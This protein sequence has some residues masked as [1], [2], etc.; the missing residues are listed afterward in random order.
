MD[1]LRLTRRRF[2]GWAASAVAF[3]T[4][5][6]ATSRPSRATGDTEV[7][8]G[9]FV[10]GDGGRDAT[11]LTADGRA[12]SVSITPDAYVTHGTDGIVETLGTFVPGEEV[13][14][15]G[16][17]STDGVAAVEFQSVYANATGRLVP[18]NS[19]YVLITST[20]A[21][22]HVPPD[23]ARRGGVPEQGSEAP[24]SATIWTDPATG[25]ATVLVLGQG[26]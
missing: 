21:R 6:G 8:V 13:V 10:R 24:R 23:V 5:L 4:A 9:R 16:T 26:A 15:R 2:F 11:V 1:S 19:G 14:V 7:T 18:E 17:A 25:D 3:A 12:I 20:G 22:M